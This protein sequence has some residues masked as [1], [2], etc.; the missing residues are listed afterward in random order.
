MA[1]SIGLCRNPTS[2][3]GASPPRAAPCNATHRFELDGELWSPHQR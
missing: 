1:A 3:I 2:A